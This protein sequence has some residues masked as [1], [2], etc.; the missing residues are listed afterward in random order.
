MPPF[1]GKPAKKPELS[2]LNSDGPFIICA[3][4]SALVLSPNELATKL[5]SRKL[6]DC[7]KIPGFLSVS[8]R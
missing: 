7:L 6:N 3:F 5:I 8:K 2:K 1:S 4:P